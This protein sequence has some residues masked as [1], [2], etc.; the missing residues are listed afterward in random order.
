MSNRGGVAVRPV[1]NA[2]RHEQVAC[3]PATPLGKGTE[4]WL[5][6]DPASNTTAGMAATVSAAAVRASRVVAVPTLRN[7]NLRIDREAVHPQEPHQVTDRTERRQPI[8]DDR[9]ERRE[10]VVG[11]HPIDAAGLVFRDH[12]RTQTSMSS[13]AVRSRMLAL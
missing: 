7:G 1:G 2:D 9:K 4:R 12:E 11:R 10:L 13:S 6:L 3:L 5:G 8:A